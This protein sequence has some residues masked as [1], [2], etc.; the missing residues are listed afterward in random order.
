MGRVF[1]ASMNMRGAWAPMPHDECFRVNVTSAQSKISAYRLA[2]S[3][4]TEVIGAAIRASFCF[5]NYWQ[6]GK[7]YSGHDDNEVEKM[8]AWWRK[9]EKGKEALSP[10]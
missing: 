10:W 1:I 9:Q 2:F 8:L 5:E 6:S 7:R 3:P 4:M